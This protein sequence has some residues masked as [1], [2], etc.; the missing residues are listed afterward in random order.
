M[1]IPFHR[2]GE[3]P[4]SAHGATPA[5]IQAL[6]RSQQIYK[7]ARS[8][9]R[10]QSRRPS[11]FVSYMSLADAFPYHGQWKHKLLNYFTKTP[12]LHLPWAAAFDFERER[13]SANLEEEYR[14][15]FKEVEVFLEQM[16]LQDTPSTLDNP[17]NPH[18]P[19]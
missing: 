7:R 8:T 14:S 9:Y 10:Y 2:L 15:R 3:I 19:V 12:N 6:H 13:Q 4:G 1:Y 11:V 18:C 16:D 5:D 17:C